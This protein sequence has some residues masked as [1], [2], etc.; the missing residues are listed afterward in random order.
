[1]PRWLCPAAALVVVSCDS[2][3]TA[4]QLDTRTAPRAA[5]AADAPVQTM[6][7]L[8][9]GDVIAT[10]DASGATGRAWVEAHLIVHDGSPRADGSILVVSGADGPMPQASR[11]AESLRIDVTQATIDPSGLVRFSGTGTFSNRAGEQSFDITGTVGPR[12][13]CCLNDDY[14]V[15][16]IV[17]GN[18]AA[19][20]SF[21]A[22]TIVRD[23]G[24][25]WTSSS[26][27]QAP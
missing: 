18:A 22:R 9:P 3:P 23:P 5:T 13:Q 15:W 2:R 19:T 17:G 14:I 24:G 4:P 27:A 8:M 12:P 21:S 11:N 25:I 6:M 1:M 20:L 10:E 7:L 16:D 26:I